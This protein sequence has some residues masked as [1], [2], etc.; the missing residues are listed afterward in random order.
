MPRFLNMITIILTAYINTLLVC[1][2]IMVIDY[3]HPLTE[4][5]A[6]ASSFLIA[7]Q[8]NDT[9]ANQVT[10]LA[11]ALMAA[12]GLIFLISNYIP[13]LRWLM[14][15]LMGGSTPSANEQAA[16]E[17]ALEYLSKKSGI[18]MDE[19]HKKYTF[20]VERAGD[21]NAWAYGT[22]DIAIT[23]LLLRNASTP[24]LA[25]CIAHEMGHHEHGD[26]NFL[27][28]LSGINLTAIICNYFIIFLIKILNLLRFIPILGIL[29][30]L[31]ALCFAA[32]TWIY[33]FLRRV[34]L[35]LLENFFN[36]QIEFQ[37]DAHAVKLGLGAEAI[38]LMK[39][40]RD[41]YGNGSIFSVLFI[42]HPR[43]NSRI[44]HI[45]KLME[46]QQ[47]EM[48]AIPTAAVPFSTPVIK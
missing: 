43:A 46:R 1:P 22:R 31:L 44:R 15:I 27:L 13:P 40:F 25:A 37:A 26:T 29:T 18:P 38:E 41:I 45:E 39:F 7:A 48:A 2:V 24:M 23:T 42:D 12:G 10:T 36:R 9:W 35:F 33:C 3:V 20:S 21:L 8:L 32:V 28:I 17:S 6:W 5:H 47:K 11:F 19:I 14:R 34:P 4:A 16:I 30:M